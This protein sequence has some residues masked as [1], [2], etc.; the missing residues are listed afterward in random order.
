M[1]SFYL[2]VFLSLSLSVQQASAQRIC[3]DFLDVIAPICSFEVVQDASPAGYYLFR[4]VEGCEYIFSH[5][6]GG[7]SFT[8]DPYLT[9]ADEDC[10]AIVWNDD[11]CGLGS[12]LTWTCTSTAFFQLHMGTFNSGCTALTRTLAYKINSPVPAISI[13]T[14]S[15]ICP[16]QSVELTAISDF[17][18][19]WS[20]ATGLSC[21][22]CPNPIASPNST[23]TYTAST[24]SGCC[25]NSTTITVVVKTQ[26]NITQEESICSGSTFSFAGNDLSQS[27][28]YMHTFNA[29]NGC[30]SIV[31][32]NLD[33]VDITP[34]IESFGGVLTT[35][36]AGFSY[37]WIDCDNGNAPIA[38]ANSQFFVPTSDG[39]YAVQISSEIGCFGESD[40][41]FVTQVQELN[42]AGDL[43]IFPNPTAGQFFISTK[44]PTT[45]TIANELGQT[46][47]QISLKAENRFIA[48]VND[49]ASGVYFV[50]DASRS[51]VKK[52]AVI[53]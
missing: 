28:S 24:T 16:G 27:G 48:E 2:I 26:Y 25:N 49:L 50:A 17:P 12:E 29:V 37:Q 5:C 13:N 7:G 15:P 22:V 41:A 33:V 6:Q 44:K 32:L 52:I 19:S 45:I 30:D 51:F 42:A 46:V 40:C 14:V 11:S 1:K 47:K 39:N 43:V 3:C 20:P 53:K 10:N 38:G 34:T 4:G 9:I 18:V 36:Q 8:G 31:T 21:N 23:T 35:P